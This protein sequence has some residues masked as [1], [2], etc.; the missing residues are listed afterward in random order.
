MQT[1]SNNIQQYCI[2]ECLIKRLSSKDGYQCVQGST[3]AIA[4]NHLWIHARES[5]HL[6][7]NKPKNIPS[8]T[9]N[10]TYSQSTSRMIF[11]RM[12]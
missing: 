3:D 9:L 1:A 10:V 4:D 6:H 8:G 7:K 5:E 12:K 2:P 11:P